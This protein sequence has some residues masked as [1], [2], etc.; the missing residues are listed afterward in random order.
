MPGIRGL[1]PGRVRTNFVLFAVAAPG[2]APDA[3]PD[4]GLRARFLD[5]CAADGLLLVA[6]PGGRIRACT[7]Y[8]IETAHVDRAIEIIRAALADVGAAHRALAGAPA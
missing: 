8:G 5:R 7:H 6:Y 1:D 4:P 3:R 2:A